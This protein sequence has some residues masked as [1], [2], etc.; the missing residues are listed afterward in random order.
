MLAQL[1]HPG[2]VDADSTRCQAVG[3]ENA[4]TSP[5][6]VG[7]PSRRSDEG[8]TGTEAG[9]DVRKT[10]QHMDDPRS[11]VP[12]GGERARLRGSHIRRYSR[13]PFVSGSGSRR[14]GRPRTP[15]DGAQGGRRRSW[16]LQT[17]YTGGELVKPDTG[18]TCR[19]QWYRQ[20]APTSQ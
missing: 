9:E 4:P 14:R 19:R 17:D 20:R 8:K 7:R 5:Q 16:Q 10:W 1:A 11:E 18:L 2:G 13:G 3:A 15:L 6:S 12:E